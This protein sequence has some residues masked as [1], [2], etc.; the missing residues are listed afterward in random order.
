MKPTIECKGCSKA[1]K[2]HSQQGQRA[3]KDGLCTV[4]FRACAKWT[5]PHSKKAPKVGSWYRKG[6]HWNAVVDSWLTMRGGK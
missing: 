3:L 2:A 4:C 6:T 1:I 5:S